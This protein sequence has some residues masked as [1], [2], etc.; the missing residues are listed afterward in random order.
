MATTTEGAVHVVIPITARSKS[1]FGGACDEILAALLP[2][3]S[4]L[5]DRFPIGTDIGD[6][7]HTVSTTTHFFDPEPEPVEAK[8]LSKRRAKKATPKARRKTRR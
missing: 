1:A 4:E 8:P 6:A 2:S 5:R 3:I 7:T